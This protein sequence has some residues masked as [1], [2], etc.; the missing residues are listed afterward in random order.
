VSQLFPP[1]PGIVFTTTL[2]E[3][4]VEEKMTVPKPSPLAAIPRKPSLS[5]FIL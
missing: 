1:V 5:A 4:V 2:V 3:G